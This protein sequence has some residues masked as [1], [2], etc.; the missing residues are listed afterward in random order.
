METMEYVGSLFMGDLLMPGEYDN[1]LKW[2]VTAEFTL[3]TYQSREE[4]MQLRGIPWPLFCA[5]GIVKN[6]RCFVHFLVLNQRVLR[7]S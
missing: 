1:Q 7:E 5:L 2:L 6:G 4:N 3:R